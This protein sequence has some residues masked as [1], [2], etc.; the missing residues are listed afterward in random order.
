MGITLMRVLF[1]D[2]SADKFDDADDEHQHE[3]GDVRDV[4]HVAVVAVADG[5]VA[6][7][8]APATPAMAVRFKRLTIVMV[9]PRAMAAMLSLRY[10]RKMISS[11]SSPSRAP[12]R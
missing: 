6:E 5:E 3:H 1:D 10:T 11:G 9:V 8:P 12:P 4:G 2:A 7:A